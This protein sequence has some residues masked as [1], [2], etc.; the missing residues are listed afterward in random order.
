MCPGWWPGTG[1]RVGCGVGG[2]DG[3]F[4][5]R[6]NRRNPHTGHDSPQLTI[7]VGTTNRVFIDRTFMS[8]PPYL[9]Q[10]YTHDGSLQWWRPHT[11]GHKYV[12]ISGGSRSSSA[13]RAASC[14]S[15]SVSNSR[16]PRAWL[17]FLQHSSVGFSSGEPR[18]R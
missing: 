5:L 2:R 11:H 8:N 14:N 18:G 7:P 6:S 15:S 9:S 10:K 4:L 17:S 16:F 12:K 1:H 13:E 3:P